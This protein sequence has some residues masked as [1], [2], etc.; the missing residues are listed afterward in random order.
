MF[1]SPI[2]TFTLEERMYLYNQNLSVY[3]A[4]GTILGTGAKLKSLLLCNLYFIVIINNKE[5][6][7]KLKVCKVIYKCYGG[8]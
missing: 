5:Y 6:K 3:Y 2:K 4:P 7:V 1:N 8:N